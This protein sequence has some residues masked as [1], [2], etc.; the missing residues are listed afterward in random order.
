MTSDELTAKVAALTERVGQL[1]RMVGAVAA[2]LAPRSPRLS[3]RPPTVFLPPQP[4]GTD[5]EALEKTVRRIVE[6]APKG[7]GA[8]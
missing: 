1:E 8:P 7:G 3:V 4:E 2:G 6:S 5:M